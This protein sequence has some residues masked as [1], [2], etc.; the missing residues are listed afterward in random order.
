MY[1]LLLTLLALLAPLAAP[2]HRKLRLMVRGHRDT[3]RLLRT[4]VV[5]GERYVW[6]HAASLGEFEQGR[7]LIERFRRQHPGKRIL[8][9][10]FSPSGY[11]VRKDY[12]GADLVL[13]LPF[14]TPRAA[15]R[16]VGLA[17]PEAAYF[18]KYEFW[19]NYIR[20][21]HRRG[22]PVYSVSSIF[23][24]GQIFFRHY[25]GS[26]ARVLRKVTWFF[27]QNEESAQ[28]LRSI[29]IECVTVVGDT[30]F[31]RVIDIRNAA[32]P[33]PLVEQFVAPANTDRRS[34]QVLVAGSTWPPCEDLIIPYLN[35]APPDFKVILAP[36]V[37]SESHLAEIEAKLHVPALRY[38]RAT[39]EK[40]AAAR[41]LI[42]DSYGLLSSIYR[43][44]TVAYVGGGFGVGIHNVP[45][46]AV[47]G[48]PVIIGP[49]NHKFREARALIRLGGC[50]EV[51]TQEQFDE[52]LTRLLTDTEALARAS[53]ASADYIAANSG[54]SDI[55]FNATAK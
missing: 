55:V 34:P 35:A 39:P 15:R 27:V 8:L 33:L 32:R 10:F 25:A 13:Y 48:I 50:I 21:L 37:V 1:S 38:S 3:W 47:Y 26:Y 42:I 44:A 53:R 11:E 49:N 2:F 14:D 36:H 6:F 30:R 4:R 23:R 20:Q 29:G 9:T 24:P 40:L 18:I 52:A 46:A 31:D 12:P 54:A 7:P 16:F 5:P 19:H 22:I 28:L 43:Y 51:K 41:C 45:E 17:R